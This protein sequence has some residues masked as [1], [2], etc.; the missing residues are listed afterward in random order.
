V[1]FVGPMAPAQKRRFPVAFS[2]SIAA[3]LHSCM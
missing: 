3:S 1:R 2:T